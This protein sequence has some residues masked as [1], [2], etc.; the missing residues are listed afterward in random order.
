MQIK[1][2][3]LL[4]ENFLYEKNYNKVDFKINCLVCDYYV[5]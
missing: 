2:Y 1:Y 3:L 4:E 5:I